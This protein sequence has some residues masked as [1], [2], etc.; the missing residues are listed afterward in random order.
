MSSKLL[1]QPLSPR[2]VEI[3][4]LVMQGYDYPGIARLKSTSLGA[5]KNQMTL[6]FKKTGTQRRVQLILKVGQERR[7]LNAN[8]S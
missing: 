5:I 2:Q 1:G 4:N 7:N 3:L 8:I 6:I